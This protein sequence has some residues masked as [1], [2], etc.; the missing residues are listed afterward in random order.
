[1]ACADTYCCECQCVA[2][3]FLVLIFGGSLTIRLRNRTKP[4]P[5][6]PVEHPATG[7]SCPTAKA[8][9][10]GSQSEFWENI[11]ELRAIEPIE[12]LQWQIGGY[13][14]TTVPSMNWL[15]RSSQVL[16]CMPFGACHYNIPLEVFRWRI[17]DVTVCRKLAPG[18]PGIGPT[19][20]LT[21]VYFN[22]R[23]QKISP[24]YLKWAQNK[25]VHLG[26]QVPDEQLF[27]WPKAGPRWPN[28]GITNDGIDGTDSIEMI[29]KSS[30]GYNSKL[31]WSGERCENI[32]LH[33]S[34]I[35][36][37][38]FKMCKTGQK[39]N[40][41]ECK[42]CAERWLDVLCLE[43]GQIWVHIDLHL[44]AL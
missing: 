6:R 31:N 27:R 16:L 7:A 4:V 21:G 33:A 20:P 40:L 39:T 17:K 43:G 26:H 37:N 42:A 2:V 44:L 22:H 11:Y 32:S 30:Y 25:R 15:E 5:E 23:Q 41:I 8:R 9:S 13:T 18:W 38:C 1:M 12:P 34:C 3:F 29:Q 28:M 19:Y 35:T 14:P 24:T 36:Q 10:H